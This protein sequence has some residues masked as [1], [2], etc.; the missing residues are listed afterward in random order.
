M[1][2]SLRRSHSTVRAY[3]DRLRNLMELLSDDPLD[4]GKSIALI[5]HIVNNRSSA[6]QVL[7]ALEDHR[8]LGA[9]C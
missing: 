8:A 4:E 7:A 1:A 2:L 9:S 3:A 6:A 5:T